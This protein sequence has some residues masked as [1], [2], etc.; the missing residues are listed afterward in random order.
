MKVPCPHCQKSVE[1]EEKSSFRP[2]CSQRCKYADLHAWANESY[3]IT[4]S[5]E[6]SDPHMNQATTIPSEDYQ[7]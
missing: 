6:A 3:V 2:F 5:N 1:W 7:S 4:E